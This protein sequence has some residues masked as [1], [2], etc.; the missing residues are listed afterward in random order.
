LCP[1]ARARTEHPTPFSFRFVSAAQ[2]Q[3]RLCYV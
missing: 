3:Y 2:L 1:P